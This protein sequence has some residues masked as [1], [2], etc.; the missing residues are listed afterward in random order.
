M[1]LG[2]LAYGLISWLAGG[3]H[4]RA[5]MFTGL[6]FVAGLALLFRVDVGLGRF[7]ARERAL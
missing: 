6:F 3:E 2:P 5:L 4:S 1:I 7:Q